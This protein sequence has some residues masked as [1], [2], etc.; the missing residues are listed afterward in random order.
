M[1]NNRVF[2]I[3]NYLSCI[4]ALTKIHL[5]VKYEKYMNKASGIVNF[6]NIS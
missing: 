1:N 2:Q 3:N 4:G 6:K 5:A